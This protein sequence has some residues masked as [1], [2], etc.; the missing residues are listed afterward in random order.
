MPPSPRWLLL[1][2]QR[3]KPSLEPS[4][5][6]HPLRA[7]ALASL[8]RFRRGLPLEVVEAELNEIC[9]SL[10][11]EVAEEGSYAELFRSPRALIAGLGLI[12]LQQLTGQ[13]SVLNYQE[14]IFED[15]G[16][17]SFASTAAVIVGAAKLAAT[18]CTVS[19]VDRF[20]RRPLLFIGIGM[21]LVA[22]TLLTVGFQLASPDVGSGDSKA[23]H[24]AQ[25]WPPVIIFALVLYV[26]GYQIGFGPITWLIISEV[27]P[28]R[29]RTRALSMAVVVNF[30]FNLG[31]TFAL[32][33]MEQW[34]DTLSP[35]RGPSYLFMIYAMFSVLSMLFVYK[36]VPETKGKS[37][38]Q[39][40]AMLR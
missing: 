29:T 21:M 34:I 30:G 1:R 38:E 23:V 32:D 31:V 36:C 12:S 24:L 11:S 20:G 14:P 16:F 6:Q 19:I 2:Y 13:P 7:A 4:D 10:D 22:L 8:V 28:L 9:A 33:P 27:F 17:A 35:G 26:C 5:W 39:I 18:L 3:A 25:G 15:A 37:L 40:E